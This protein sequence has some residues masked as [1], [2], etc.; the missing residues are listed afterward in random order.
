[1]QIDVKADISA[2]LRKLDRVSKE[3]TD[4]AVVRALNRVAEQARTQAAREIREA[5]YNVKAAALKK[6]MDLSKA[7]QGRL[8]ARVR[9]TGR[10]IP[11]INYDAKP[12][13]NGVAVKVKGARKVIAH[14]FIV[15]LP[16]GHR[17]VFERVGSTHKKVMHN[18]V[19]QW[20]GLPIKQLFGPAIPSMFANKIVQDALERGV[21]ERFPERF[22]HELSRLNLK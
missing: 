12:V 3:V 7:S 22:K 13:K 8:V 6:A 15:T 5:G 11:L 2:A 18:G 4:K 16:S 20:R 9:A 19:A 21:R 10:P 1:M 17:G 14:A